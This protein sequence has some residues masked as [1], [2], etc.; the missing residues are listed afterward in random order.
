MENQNLTVQQVSEILKLSKATIWRKC[1]EHKLRGAFKM[2]GSHK[3]LI[4]Q[5]EFEKQQKELIQGNYED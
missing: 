3:W 2:P 5:K 1:Q 4:N